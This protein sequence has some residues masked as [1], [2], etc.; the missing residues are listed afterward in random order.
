MQGP[1]VFGRYPTI[2]DEAKPGREDPAKTENHNSTL[3]DSLFFRIEFRL[4]RAS[5]REL[6]PSSASRGG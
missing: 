2:A 3:M 1:S 5:G 4:L 6:W